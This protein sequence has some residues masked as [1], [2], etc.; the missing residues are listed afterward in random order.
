MPLLLPRPLPRPLP[1]WACLLAATALAGCSLPGN[2]PAPAPA[3]PSTLA[4]AA[5]AAAC[6]PSALPAL[7]GVRITEATLVAAGSQRAKLPTGAEVGPPLPEHCLLRGRIDE[8]TGAD[9]QP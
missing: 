4:A 1:P 2:A 5:A 3:R 8:R 6:Q 7:P 9:G